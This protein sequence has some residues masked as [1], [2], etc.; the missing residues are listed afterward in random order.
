M[1]INSEV[2]VNCMVSRKI[3]SAINKVSVDLDLSRGKTLTKLIELGLQAYGEAVERSTTTDG[4][5]KKNGVPV[6]LNMGLR[7]IL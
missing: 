4:V 3:L 5:V 7:K 2:S 1:S 6:T